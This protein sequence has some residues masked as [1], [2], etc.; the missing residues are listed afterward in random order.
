MFTLAV[1][2][3]QDQAKWQASFD[4]EQSHAARKA[5]GETSH[6]LFRAV[7]RPRTFVLLNQWESEEKAKQFIQSDTLRQMQQVSGVVGVPQV[8][9][10]EEVGKGSA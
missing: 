1:I 9:F 2:E 5:A 10:L 8:F 7:D 6:Q 4:T 3:V